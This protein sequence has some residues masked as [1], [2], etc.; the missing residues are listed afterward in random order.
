MAIPFSV[1]FISIAMF[2]FA[3]LG[4][5]DK[6]KNSIFSYLTIVGSTVPLIFL[7]NQNSI[8]LFLS[9]AITA[10]IILLIT[11][12]IIRKIVAWA[13]GAS[14]IAYLGM[15]VVINR[16]TVMEAIY[17]YKVFLFFYVAIAILTILVI[18]YPTI[19]KIVEWIAGTSIISFMAIIL[20][21]YR[22]NLM[23]SIYKLLLIPIAI[24][25]IFSEDISTA[26][27][28]YFDT[29]DMKISKEV[30]E[31]KMIDDTSDYMI[32]GSYIGYTFAYKAEPSYFIL[33]KDKVHNVP[34]KVPYKNL[35]CYEGKVNEYYH[36]I[37][38]NIKTNGVLH[39]VGN[40]D[41]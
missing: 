1:F 24:I 19:R 6:E 9:V 26:K 8:F 29:L 35:V 13:T 25:G 20:I 15:M 16:E 18:I 36:K 21:F 32:W 4:I 38:Y 17:Q 14:V 33:I 5:Q 12:P 11:Y 22:E 41:Y 31:L 40:Q 28:T 34:C 27:S 10:A 3:F 7:W 23:E 39:Y 30:K 37:E 2:I